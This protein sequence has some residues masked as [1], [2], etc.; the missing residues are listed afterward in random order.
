M[1][2]FL[3]NLTNIQFVFALL[4]VFQVKHLLGDYV[5]QTGWMV[6]GKGRSGA[7]FVFPLS[8]HVLVHAVMTLGIL[9]V[10]HPKM[11]YLALVDFAA[12]FIMDRIKASPQLFGRYSDTTKQSFWIPLGFDQ[13]VHHLTHYLII[14]LLLINR[15]G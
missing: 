3:N 7:G 6:R 9:L 10:V 2:S 8:V 11:W 13:M 5:F 1:T 14:F 12:H 15:A 4:V